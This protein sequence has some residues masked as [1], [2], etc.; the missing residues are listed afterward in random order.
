MENIKLHWDR[1]T[2]ESKKRF[3]AFAKRSL[4]RSQCGV[5]YRYNSKSLGCPKETY[6]GYRRITN[7][8][9]DFACSNLCWKL[10]GLDVGCPCRVFGYAA[11]EALCNIP[12][13]KKELRRS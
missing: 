12:E 9:D 11:F 3:I 2:P 1:L 8:K 5:D 4:S 7:T 13:V 10:F 6:F